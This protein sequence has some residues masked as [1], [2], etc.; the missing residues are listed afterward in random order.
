MHVAAKKAGR[1]TFKSEEKA[2]KQ[3]GLSSHDLLMKALAEKSVAFNFTTSKYFQAYVSFISGGRFAAPSSYHL[4]KALARMSERINLA[5]AARLKHHSFFTA[6]VH[7]WSFKGR[8]L[9]AVTV[10]APGFH[11]FACGYQIWTAD[12]AVIAAQAVQGCGLEALGLPCDLPD[13]SD[14]MPRGKLCAMTTDT[15]AVMPAMQRAAL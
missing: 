15:T 1:L 7:S 2:S 14:K 11:G 10:S 12:W 9:F 6:Q 5:M 13:E 3:Q 8:H 4:I